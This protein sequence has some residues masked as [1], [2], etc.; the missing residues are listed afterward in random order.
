MQNAENTFFHTWAVLCS[1]D[2]PSTHGASVPDKSHSSAV[3]GVAYRPVVLLLL[4]P[5]Q[6]HPEPSPV[7]SGKVRQGFLHDP[8]MLLHEAVQAAHCSFCISTFDGVTMFSS[9]LL[10]VLLG[11]DVQFLLHFLDNVDGSPAFLRLVPSGF[12]ADSSA[13]AIRE[14]VSS[15]LPSRFHPYESVVLL[16]VYWVRCGRCGTS[17][18]FTWMICTS[19][20]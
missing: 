10:H 1:H 18:S 20:W 2:L 11:D 4:N 5:D 16:Q 8:V 6:D 12:P 3:H 17:R 14:C 7:P 15:N 19:S 13:A 9:C